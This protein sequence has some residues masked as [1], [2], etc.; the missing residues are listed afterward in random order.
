MTFVK[1]LGEYFQFITRNA[2]EEVQL[3]LEIK[4]AMNYIRIQ[5][6]RFHNRVETIV[7]ELPQVT[8]RVRVPR[9]ILQPIIENAYKHGL[10]DREE[11]GVLWFRFVVSG[12][13][14][15]IEVENNGALITDEELLNVR[16]KLQTDEPGK[17]TTGMINVHRRLRIRYGE[18]GGLI[19]ERGEHGGWKVGIT[20]PFDERT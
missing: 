12:P 6:I 16:R 3:S 19:V 15:T 14:I 5:G 1:Y 7:G 13:C 10:E 9:L 4:H 20:I 18:T 11:G 2:D 17:E 8:E